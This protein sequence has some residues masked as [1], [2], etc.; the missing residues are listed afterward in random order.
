M[1]RVAKE[2]QYSAWYWLE[3]KYAFSMFIPVFHSC[4]HKNE[5]STFFLS[6]LGLKSQVGFHDRLLSLVRPP[7]LLSVCELFTFSSFPPEPLDQFQHNLA[8]CINWWRGFKFVQTNGHSHFKGIYW[9]KR[10]KPMAIS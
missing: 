4:K 10:I 7:V 5:D 9:R 3:P 8:Q 6:S 2:T 1:K